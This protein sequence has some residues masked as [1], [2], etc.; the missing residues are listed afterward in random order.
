MSLIGKE[1]RSWLDAAGRKARLARD[2]L[3]LTPS[4][5]CLVLLGA[6]AVWFQGIG[7]LDLVLLTAGVL[8]GLLTFVLMAATA[9]AALLVARRLRAG[10]AG[11]LSLECGV[12]HGTDLSARAPRWLPFLSLRAIWTQPPRVES[13]L[14]GSGGEERVKPRRRGRYRAVLRQFTLEDVLG[15]TA[16]TWACRAEGAVRI[17]PARAP[18]NRPAEI[19]GL[20]GGEDLSDPWGVPMGDRV[21]M[22]KYGHGDS[23][24]MIL[25]KTFARTRRL[26]VRT[27]ERAIEAAPRICA[28]LLSAPEDEPAASV[29]RSVL[30][31]GLLGAGW[32][33]G[34]DGAEDA[35][36]LPGA[37]EALAV[38]GARPSEAPTLLAGFLQR[39]E[40]DGFGSCVLFLP[41]R[42]GSWTDEVRIVLPAT[43]LRVRAVIAVPGWRREG[44]HA[45]WRRFLFSPRPAEGASPAEVE[46]LVAGLSAPGMRFALADVVSGDVLADPEEFLGRLA[47]D[48]RREV[49]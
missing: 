6:L 48:G 39:A 24:R 1:P 40:R 44:S 41:P 22:R 13:D 12:W 23:P 34:A 4:G 20:V 18:L 27:P 7:S 2:L 43:S 49:A 9:A 38:S 33:F 17:V 15:L 42:E 11:N 32:R 5:A 16:V 8:A 19:Q 28:Y 30:E 31:L 36:D 37:L 47:A 3:P 25:W 46:R 45:W 10:S 21:D 14:V 35:E 29:A 26:F